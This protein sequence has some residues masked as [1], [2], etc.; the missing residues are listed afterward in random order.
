MDT[1]NTFQPIT[2]S[3]LLYIFAG[4]IVL[5]LAGGAC[6]TIIF[7]KNPNLMIEFRKTEFFYIITVFGIVLATVVLGL[8]GILDGKSISAILGGI[9]GYVLGSL[10][11]HDSQQ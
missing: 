9:V 4:I 8:R 11:K 3:T 10:R 5:A 6:L 7:R 2:D 1:I